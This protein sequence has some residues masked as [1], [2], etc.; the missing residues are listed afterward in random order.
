[1]AFDQHIEADR[2]DD[3]N[4]F[5]AFVR[6]PLLILEGVLGQ[7]YE[8]T[9]LIESR[10]DSNEHM[11]CDGESASH[12]TSPSRTKMLSN[13]AVSSTR[14][15]ELKKSESVLANRTNSTSLS[16]GFS[17]S[18]ISDQSSSSLPGLKRTTKMSWSDESGLSLVEYSDEVSKNEL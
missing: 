8:K 7:K 10:L 4:L 12:T 14:R 17:R 3:F 13:D 1:M 5:S 6:V 2:I 16:S 11:D 18:S 15:A 9:G